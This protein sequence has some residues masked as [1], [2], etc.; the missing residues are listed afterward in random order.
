MHGFF[1]SFIKLELKTCV[2]FKTSSK[3]TFLLKMTVS[4]VLLKTFSKVRF[5]LRVTV[6]LV[7]VACFARNICI[8]STS[9]KILILRI[10][11]L[12]K[13]ILGVLLIKVFLI[14]V[15]ALGFFVLLSSQKCTRNLFESLK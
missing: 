15:L 1:I 11:V 9:Q 13:F 8:K 7:G 3:L 14:K 2:L 5:L 6:S 4:F 12:R 10:L